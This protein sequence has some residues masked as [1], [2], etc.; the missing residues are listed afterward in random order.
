MV[1]QCPGSGLHGHDRKLDAVLE[2][3]KFL[4]VNASVSCGAVALD[5]LP[6]S[7]A[8][9]LVYIPFNWSFHTLLIF[10]FFSL[11][12]VTSFLSCHHVTMFS[13]NDDDDNLSS[14]V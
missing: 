12:L 8:L 13:L 10:F 5:S 9:L 3:C 11:V 6:S 1:S 2:G 14:L 4:P 7:N